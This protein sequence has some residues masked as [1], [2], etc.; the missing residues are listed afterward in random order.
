MATGIQLQFNAGQYTPS[1]GTSDPLCDG[2]HL[3][4]V[5]DS[6]VEPT[7]SN[8]GKRLTLECTV[9]AGDFKGSKYWES[10]NI[11]NPSEKA[12]EIAYEN[13][14]ALAEATCGL[15]QF[16]QSQNTSSLFGIPFY[17]KVRTRN[18]YQNFAGWKPQ[19]DQSVI[20]ATRADAMAA[21]QA[22]AG[23][24]PPAAQV[25]NNFQPQGGG[26]QPQGGFQQPAPQQQPAQTGFA[27]QTGA[28]PGFAPQAAPNAQQG[29]GFN[30]PMAGMNQQPQ[31]QPQGQQPQPQFQQAP[32]QQA[33]AFNQAPQQQMQ[34]PMQQQQ[35]GGFQPPQQPQQPQF[36][37]QQQGGFQPQGMPQQPGWGQPQ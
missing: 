24:Q 25:T 35:Q 33:P 30:Q 1:T 7:Q 9:L 21:K 14:L 29:A 27:P 20:V 15:A 3:L 18:D 8:N 16:S 37:Q 28:A 10:Y 32:Q 11:E 2:W 26:F 31:F 17:G 34:Q 4:A 13:L 23:N 36:Q 12:V 19:T 22:Q 5:T 6:K